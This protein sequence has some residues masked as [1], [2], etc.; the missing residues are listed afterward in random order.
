MNIGKL[1]YFRPG[2]IIN[3]SIYATHRI[4]GVMIDCILENIK[5]KVIKRL[6]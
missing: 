5:T 1:S 3:Y 4:F 6:A 2:K